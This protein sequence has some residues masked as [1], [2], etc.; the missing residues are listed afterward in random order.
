MRYALTRLR[1]RSVIRGGLSEG[2]I[3]LRGARSPSLYSFEHG[4]AFFALRSI[5]IKCN[6][7]QHPTRARARARAPTNALVLPVLHLTLIINFLMRR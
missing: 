1:K 4:L 6:V 5:L 3:V 2:S 7:T